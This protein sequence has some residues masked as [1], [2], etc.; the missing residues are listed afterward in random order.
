MNDERADLMANLARKLGRRI[1]DP[2]PP[3]AL[4]TT[5]RNHFKEK[6]QKAWYTTGQPKKKDWQNYHRKSSV[7]PCLRTP[8]QTEKL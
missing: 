7:H 2:L 8:H 6:W 4:T 3:T 5:L 1:N